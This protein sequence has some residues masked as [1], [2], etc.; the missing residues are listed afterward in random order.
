MAIEM[1]SRDVRS[2]GYLGCMGMVSEKQVTVSAD[3]EALAK[4]TGASSTLLESLVKVT[5]ADNSL[6]TD[7]L[8]EHYNDVNDPDNSSSWPV[9]LE[10]Y[11][12]KK[13][14][15]WPKT[16]VL[17]LKGAEPCPGGRVTQVN[18]AA[19]AGGTA[20]IKIED[21]EACGL[22]QNDIVVLANCS[23]TDIFAITNNPSSGS[24]KST[25][26]HGAGINISPKLAGAYDTDSYIYRYRTEIF[27]VGPGSNGEPSLFLKRLASTASS[28]PLETL[29][30]ARGIED[31][32]ILLGEDSDKTPDQV[33][34]RYVSTVEKMDRVVSMKINLLARSEA[35][36]MGNIDQSYFFTLEKGDPDNE[37]A[38]LRLPFQATVALR[39]RVK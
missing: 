11:G 24:D 10:G 22:Q 32:Q 20:Q 23:N 21:A 36:V 39:N 3:L 12:L 7:Q 4:K 5:G 34:N 15:V 28:T 29:E 37:K 30:L 19:A 27:Y 1:L 6:D 14:D 35:D 26:A 31:L 13:T 33:A 8:I 2:A 9:A 25:L 17:V 38:R 16:D 18:G